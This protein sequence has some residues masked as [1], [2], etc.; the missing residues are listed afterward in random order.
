MS[1]RTPGS[2]VFSVSP[3]SCHSGRTVGLN[4]RPACP[5]GRRSRWSRSRPA[6]VGPRQGVCKEVAPT[7]CWGDVS[8][9]REV[10]SETFYLSFLPEAQR[11][12]KYQSPEGSWRPENPENRPRGTGLH[13]W[14]RKGACI[15]STHRRRGQ[16]GA[17]A[18]VPTG[19]RDT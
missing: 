16:E 7:P 19:D 10:S 9:P 12:E 14:G 13:P 1:F 2:N 11:Q 3:G 4:V 15:D 5:P 17:A 8:F 18:S 6:T